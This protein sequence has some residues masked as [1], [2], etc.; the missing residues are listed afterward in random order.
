MQRIVPRRDARHDADRLAHHDRVADLL[1]PLEVAEQLRVHAERE[2]RRASL[3]LRREL[4][5]H[6]DFLSDRAADLV[7]ARL[8]SL[9]DLG[10]HGGALGR[11]GRAPA[12]E[13]G[14][15]G[16]DRDRGV[17]GVAFGDARDH[18]L[19]GGGVNVDGSL[20]VRRDPR[21]VEIQL[22][23]DLH[24]NLAEGGREGAVAIMRAMRRCPLFGCLAALAA[25]GRVL[26]ADPLPAYGADGD[27]ITVS[28]ISSGGFMAVQFHVAHSRTVTGVG[29]LAGGPYY[30]A[31]GSLWTGF[32]GCTTPS[33]W[34]PL[35]S[36]EL[37][38]AEA[39]LLAR[40]RLIDPTENLSSA[41][42]WLF[43]GGGDRTV[44]A[45]VVDA[46]RR[47]YALYRPPP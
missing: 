11:R 12:L 44:A 8:H 42:A 20:A 33:A 13:C 35:P 41:R 1:L 37:L 31:Q 25:A 36:V 43:S 38:K 32:Y 15:R 39:D 16:A 26:A 30:C 40:A 23:A 29:V 45:A 21:P 3:D 46:A 4:H 22:V 6:A 17:L 7:A 18:F 28:G 27:A 9:L 14:A 10:E 34:A 24:V 47:F 19:G 5:R 2:R